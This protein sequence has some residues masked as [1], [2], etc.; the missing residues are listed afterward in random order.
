MRRYFLSLLST[1]I[2]VCCQT[3][4]TPIDYVDPFIGTGF[5][6]HTYPGATSP[7]GMVQ[8]SP[9]TRLSGWDACSGYHWD[10]SLMYGFSHTHLSGTG[11]ADLCDV[12]FHPL[13]SD[14]DLSAA[15]SLY[16]PYTFSHDDESATCGY[17]RVTLP[18]EGMTVELTTT[19]RT[20]VHRYTFQ[21]GGKR[22][23][24]VDLA[25]TN[26]DERIDRSALTTPCDSVLEGM[27]LT[28]G[29]VADQFI[30][31]SAKFSHTFKVARRVDDRL[32]LLQFP[33]DID[34][35]T[36][37]VGLSAVSCKNARMNR[38]EEVSV[39]DFDRVK[40]C[41]HEEWA[42]ALSDIVV[43]GG[44]EKSLTNFYTAQYHSKL[45]PNLMSDV[46]GEY[47]RNNGEIASLPEGRKYYSTMSLWDTFRGWNP[48]Q[49]LVNPS[50]VDDVV[51]S[52]MDMYDARGELPLWPLSSGE[53]ECMIGY[54]AVSVMA[55]AYLRGVTTYDGNKM[56]D[57]M[58]HS[59][60]INKKGSALRQ[61]YGYIPAN[62]KNESVSCQ[63]EFAYDDW[64][65]ARMAERLGRADVAR[66][67]DQRA[68]GYLKVFD[69]QTC[70][71]RGRNSDGSFASP[72]EEFSTGRDY[73]EATPWQYRFF[74]PHDIQGLVALFGGRERFLTEL[75]RLFSLESEEMAIDVSDVTGL[76]GQYAHGNEPSHHMA[77][78]Y[79][80]V[81]QPWKTQA[82]T[83]TLLD[84]MYQPTPEGIIGNEDCGQMSAW[85]ILS[86]MGFYSVCPASGEFSVT[87][88]LF[89]R[90][91]VTLP[92]HK[93]L[94]ITANRPQKNRYISSLSL[95][96]EPISRTFLSYDELIAGGE[97]RFELT[98]EPN[99]DF[100]SH[101]KELPYSLH[102]ANRAS[103]PYI[104]ES[105][106][107]FTDPVAVTMG[108]ATEGVDIHYTLDGSM[109]TEASPRYQSPIMVDRR[110]T[111]KAVAFK[112][113]LE[114]SAVFEIEAQPAEF[115]P[116]VRVNARRQGV[117]YT[118]Y[119][120]ACSKVA[121][122]V[123]MKRMGQGVMT[124]PSI[125]SAPQP[126]HF[127]YIFEGFIDV[128]ATGVWE[129]MTKSDDG[130]VLYIDGELV[131]SN[132]FSHAAIS[133]SGRVALHQG[134]HAYRLLYFED[135]EGEHL[136]WGWRQSA[137]D[138]FEAIP[139]EYLK[140][141]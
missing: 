127:A 135:Y 77:Y 28:Q 5:H 124:T 94:T 134:L 34:Q 112:E 58:I 96:G 44:D 132:D 53:T 98:D 2:L 64:A 87:T 102:Q 19:P 105:L 13:T 48:L 84:E 14:V 108:C 8:L 31:F 43:E 32:V 99:I 107:L 60:N 29:W 89:E 133:S 26:S 37:A 56:L 15:T 4:R 125:E 38:T 52:M 11:C 104:C 111:L 117:R 50:L 18:A 39:L 80:W 74:V 118:Y 47:R 130:S 115:K 42:K 82:M 140:I 79:N 35:L 72:F 81:G 46:N 57:A 131:V 95:N 30:F 3:S 22:F 122:I 106:Y 101:A 90:C 121:D 71:F 62:M 65:I 12:L 25:H 9:D 61:E 109:P 17:Y 24:W 129:F 88:P 69:G 59:S 100:A 70:F 110:L 85:Y 137:T 123:K 33:D 36:I 86:S 103:T 68:T 41:A 139:Q 76:K 20:G 141:K 40:A 6:G 67:Y 116:A 51:W 97:L 45:T 7:F 126:D 91:V 78:L 119:E 63:L 113:G 55:D 49:T 23:L 1:L 16:E 66:E 138:D 136:S 128:P 120:G 21:R 93:T 92:S 75:D 114:P 73:T 27:R 83:R 10:D 54:H